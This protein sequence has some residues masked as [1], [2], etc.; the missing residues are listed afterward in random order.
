M[1]DT[2]ALLSLRDLIVSA[3]SF[4]PSDLL[5]VG[6]EDFRGLFFITLEDYI[7]SYS[8]DGSRI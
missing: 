6:F 7:V 3:N 4:R 2:I 8:K 1:H 5:F